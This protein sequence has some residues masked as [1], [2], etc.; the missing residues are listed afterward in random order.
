MLSLVDFVAVCVSKAIQRGLGEPG[1]HLQ[2]GWGQSTKA[3]SPGLMLIL[4]Q[5][6]ELH[7]FGPGDAC[8]VPGGWAA[9][10]P[11][12]VQSA[13]SE[14]GWRQL[15]SHCVLPGQLAPLCS[16]LIAEK[17]Q[18]LKPKMWCNRCRIWVTPWPLRPFCS[19]ICEVILGPFIHLMQLYL[20]SLLSVKW[21]P[22]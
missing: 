11:P 8:A 14:Q 22:F 3:P 19:A 1:C 5:Q 16:H 7:A 10:Q 6:T 17:P 15:W 18:V 21:I 12:P 4:L 20:K 13:S 2:S 9:Q